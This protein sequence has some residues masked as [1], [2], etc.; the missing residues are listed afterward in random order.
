MPSSEDNLLKPSDSTRLA[1]RGPAQKQNGNTE[2][3]WKMIK[4]ESKLI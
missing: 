2:K 3:K 4:L 1:W